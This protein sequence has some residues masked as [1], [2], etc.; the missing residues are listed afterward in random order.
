M[1]K[2]KKSAVGH[3]V[4]LAV[5]R[6]GK[7]LGKQRFGCKNYGILFTRNIPDQRLENRFIWFRKWILEQQPEKI[8]RWNKIQSKFWVLL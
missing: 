3:A 6:W 8:S 7:Q 2:L 1:E 5:I 4:A